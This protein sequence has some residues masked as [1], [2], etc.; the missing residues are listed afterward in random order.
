MMIAHIVYQKIERVAWAAAH[1]DTQEPWRVWVNASVCLFGDDR[2]A[3]RKLTTGFGCCD[4][5]V[6]VVCVCTAEDQIKEAHDNS[7]E[8]YL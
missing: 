3:E 2:G 7:E 1:G 8:A 4:S 6:K 5:E